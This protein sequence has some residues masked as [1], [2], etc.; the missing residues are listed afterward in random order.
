MIAYVS[1]A[2]DHAV[3][4]Y[5]CGVTA[6]CLEMVATV[7]VPDR[8]R[9]A[10]IS[11]PLAITPDRRHLLAALRSEPFALATFEIASDGTLR[12]QGLSALAQSLASIK[13]DASGRWL[14]GA[15]FGGRAITV[16]EI[17]HDGF[18]LP[19]RQRV[20][21][22]GSKVHDVALHPS[23]KWVYATLFERGCILP[24]RF[25][26]DSGALEPE[27]DLI[28]GG[29][30][31]PRHACIDARGRYLYVLNETSVDVD[32]YAVDAD[33]GRAR[34]IQAVAQQSPKGGQPVS[35]AD[36]RLAPSGRELY[37][38]ER[39]SATISV[40]AVEGDSGLL[41][42]PAAFATERVPRSF[43]ISPSGNLLLSGGESANTLALFALSDDQPPVHLA[44]TAT[45]VA[46]NWIEFLQ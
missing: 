38:S 5:R 44:T 33:T 21:E 3:R 1:C 29:G 9:A 43:A 24:L 14:I 31:S 20:L 37:S 19:Q 8:S 15:S 2:G 25:D 32:V 17:G 22:P 34:H 30:P 35:G 42:S 13:V 12:Y 10:G 39:N 6:P 26:P 7:S 4:V 41:G 18:L 23:N 46:P 27:D 28:A 36:L 40:F 45:G 16:H 11:M